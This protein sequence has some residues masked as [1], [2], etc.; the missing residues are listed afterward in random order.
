M[1]LANFWE[2]RFGGKQQVW[3]CCVHPGSEPTASIQEEEGEEEEEELDNASPSK[4]QLMTERQQRK[5]RMRK[6]MVRSKNI[7]TSLAGGG[8][9]RLHRVPFCWSALP[10]VKSLNYRETAPIIHELAAPCLSLYTGSGRPWQTSL[11]QPNRPQT[12]G[13]VLSKS[14]L[15]LSFWVGGCIFQIPGGCVFQIPGG[16]VCFF[17]LG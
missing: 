5:A 1:H 15:T 9:G 10:T 17:L 11:R 16:C 8:G 2:C 3:T 13:R 14:F 6:L 12:L 4:T 7:I